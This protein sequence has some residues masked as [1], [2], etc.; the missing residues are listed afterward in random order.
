MGAQ[1]EA[2]TVHGRS[3]PPPL[4]LAW[5]ELLVL[6]IPSPSV[7]FRLPLTD[8]SFSIISQSKGN[9]V[10]LDF[11]DLIIAEIEDKVGNL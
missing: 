9:F 3:P 1:S 4:D 5:L 8:K 11:V 2:I 7:E 10:I 6:S